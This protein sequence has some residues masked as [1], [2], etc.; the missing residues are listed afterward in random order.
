M[1]LHH[2]R[3]YDLPRTEWCLPRIPMLGDTAYFCL[4][5]IFVAEVSINEVNFVL[6]Q[7]KKT[8]WFYIYLTPTG[9]VSWFPVS[10]GEKDKLGW[11]ITRNASDDELEGWTVTN[12]EVDVDLPVGHSSS[13]EYAPNKYERCFH[14]LSHALT[15]Q[16]PIRHARKRLKAQALHNFI[17]RNKKFI[18]ST[19]RKSVEAMEWEDY[20]RY[21]ERRVFCRRR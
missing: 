4:D 16:V 19:H 5:S 3:V 11:D 21:P 9:V 1:T 15:Y 13:L 12:W 17:G 2:H 6:T 10:T 14:N 7:G 8:N 18:A 20:K